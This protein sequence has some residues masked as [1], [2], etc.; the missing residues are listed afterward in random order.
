MR[1]IRSVLQLFPDADFVESESNIP[2]VAPSL[3]STQGGTRPRNSDSSKG[4]SPVCASRNGEQVPHEDVQTEALREYRL[5]SRCAS[6]GLATQT[7]HRTDSLEV[8]VRLATS[9]PPDRGSQASSL[10]RQPG[11]VGGSSRTAPASD[12]ANRQT[13]AADD[14]PSYPGHGV[15]L[16]RATD[17]G[18]RLAG[19]RPV[20]RT[21]VVEDSLDSRFDQRSM[22][23]GASMLPPS[24]SS[25][26]GET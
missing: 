17:G 25:D 13:D 21:E 3:A 2:L 9:S 18:V 4:T 19:G 22:E 12:G 15:G 16:R 5:L 14:V 26:F 1:V 7:L 20:D 8:W 10:S 6:Y 11:N 24:Y 23:S